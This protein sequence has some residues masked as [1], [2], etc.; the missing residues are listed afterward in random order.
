MNVNFP[1]GGSAQ[2]VNSDITSN[3]SISGNQQATVKEVSTPKIKTSQELKVAESQG[4]PIPISE[5][6]VIKAIDR[7][8]KAMQGA[9]TSLNFSVHEKTN[10]IMVKV[11]NNESGEVI[12]E[13][14]P[15]KSLDFLAKVWE[16]AGIL[17]DERR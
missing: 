5:E 2:Q 11:I 4:Q 14:P 7:A 13:I 16:M 3:Q 15:E 6:Q 12:R 8:I 17:V 9:S 1:T 10:Q